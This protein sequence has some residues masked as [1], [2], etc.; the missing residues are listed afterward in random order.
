MTRVKGERGGGKQRRRDILK[1]MRFTFLGQHWYKG[2]DELI[3][4]MGPPLII[5]LTK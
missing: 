2:A 3:V 5:N 4:I 1:I